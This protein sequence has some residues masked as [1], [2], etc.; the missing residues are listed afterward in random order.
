VEM[1]AERKAALTR[2]RTANLAEGHRGR[3]GDCCLPST[4]TTAR[5]EQAMRWIQGKHMGEFACFRVGERSIIGPVSSQ[6][7]TSGTL[8][9]S[10]RA[11]DDRGHEELRYECS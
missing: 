4:N 6:S 1:R 11:F 5:L 3:G 8:H 10:S 9:E 7:L 2:R